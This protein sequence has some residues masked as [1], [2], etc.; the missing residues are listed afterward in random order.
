MKEVT[1]G[2][3]R[4]SR[5]TAFQ[6]CG[7]VDQHNRKRDGLLVCILKVSLVV[8]YLVK[9]GSGRYDRYLVNYEYNQLLGVLVSGSLFDV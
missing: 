6:I 8:G 3:M 1:D 5:C 7:V 2:E 4:I 9:L